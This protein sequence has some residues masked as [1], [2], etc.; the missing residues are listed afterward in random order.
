MFAGVGGVIPNQDVSQV[1]MKWPDGNIDIRMSNYLLQA[2]Q[3]WKITP[4]AN[5]GGYLG[6]PY[7]KITVDGTDRALAATDDAELVAV[8]AFTGG[9]EQLWRIDQLGDGSYRIM[10]RSVPGSTEPMA[11]TAIGSSFATLTRFDP[12]NDKQRW[13]LKA[14]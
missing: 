8:P 3:K 2:Q 6:A 10:P 9:P 1:S 13:N 5:A 7:F 12:T 11:L 4:V 14:P